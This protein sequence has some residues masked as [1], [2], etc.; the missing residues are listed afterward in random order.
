[1]ARPINLP[2]HLVKLFHYLSRYISTKY[3]FFQ[4]PQH[5]HFCPSGRI[6]CCLYRHGR[7]RVV[8]WSKTP[9]LVI[10]ICVPTMATIRH[11]H[12]TSLTHEGYTYA[13]AGDEL[14]I[15]TFLHRRNSTKLHRNEATTRTISKYHWTNI[16]GQLYI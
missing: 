15:R 12:L 8:S 4:R 16:C 14:S 13:S 11:I 10:R 6:H 1:M 3:I 2:K 7:N 9:Q 5:F